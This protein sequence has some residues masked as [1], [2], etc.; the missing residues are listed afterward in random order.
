VKIFANIYW[1][2]FVSKSDLS[3]CTSTSANLYFQF[4]LHTFLL[5][6]STKI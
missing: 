5:I 3:S 6:I 4:N 1:T 2:K